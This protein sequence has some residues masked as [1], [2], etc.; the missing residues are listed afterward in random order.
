MKPS[1]SFSSIYLFIAIYVLF[2]SCKS[3][4]EEITS[5]VIHKGIINPVTP[6]GNTLTSEFA[7]SVPPDYSA[8]KKYPLVVALHGYGSS[9][10][11]FHEIWKPATDSLGMLLLTPQAEKQTPEGIGYTW[12][13]N[14]EMLVL[15]T[16]DFAMKKLNVNTDEIYLVGFSM[17]GGYAY[18]IATNHSSAF[19]G[20]ASI[21]APYDESWI[22]QYPLLRVNA[23]AYISH[24]EY[25]ERFAEGAIRAVKEFTSRGYKTK[26]VIYAET[27]H[28]LPKPIINELITIL[29]YLHN[30]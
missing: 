16:I 1:Q 13:D 27:G 20:F 7:Y 18:Q 17:G 15:S 10:E 9:S 5:G 8:S 12:G 29:N 6:S 3:P 14:T 4:F 28:T 26:Y 21:C 25:E 22:G 11:A 24:G 23:K 2:A 19:K 30:D